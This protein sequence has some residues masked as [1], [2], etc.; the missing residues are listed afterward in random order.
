VTCSR[1][2][3]SGE[4]VAIRATGGVCVRHSRIFSGKITR[5]ESMGPLPDYSKQFKLRA[6]AAPRQQ[7]RCIWL[8]T[9]KEDD[10]KRWKPCG[11]PVAVLDQDGQPLCRVHARA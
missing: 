11:R 2:G 9:V 8:I 7:E 5:P 1:P 6:L 3:C 10:C 4:V